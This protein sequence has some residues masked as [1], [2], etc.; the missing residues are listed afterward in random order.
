MCMVADGIE[1]R[2]IN[3]TR[4]AFMYSEKEAPWLLRPHLV[5]RRCFQRDDLEYLY[6]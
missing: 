2:L 5:H 4:L 1:K 6:D 3:V